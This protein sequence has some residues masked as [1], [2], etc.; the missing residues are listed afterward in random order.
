[1]ASRLMLSDSSC[2]PND[3]LCCVVCDGVSARAREFD[4]QPARTLEERM[5]QYQREADRRAE[6]GWY[7]KGVW[8]PYRMPPSFDLRAITGDH[9]V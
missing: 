6:V 1:M 2:L 8:Q 4:K 9:Q 3:M 7:S 5:L